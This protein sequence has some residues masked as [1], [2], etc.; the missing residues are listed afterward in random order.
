MA[1][2]RRDQPHTLAVTLGS[3]GMSSLWQG[4]AS[5]LLVAVHTLR[6]LGGIA[7]AMGSLHVGAETTDGCRVLRERRDGL[8]YQ[9][10]E[11]ELAMVRSYRAK[12]CPLLALRAESANAMDALHSE[13]HMPPINYAEWSACRLRA[14]R[15]LEAHHKVRYLNRQRFTFY[16]ESGAALA[17]EADRVEVAIQAKRCY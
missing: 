2:Q 12:L 13:S 15:Q 8:A 3:S 10:M 4:C 7:L 14:E 1:A 5:R 6:L 11:R 9:A 16:S 17:A